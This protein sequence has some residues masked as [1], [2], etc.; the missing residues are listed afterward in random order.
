MINFEKVIYETIQ[1]SM[2]DSAYKTM[3]EAIEKGYLG[4]KVLEEIKK[5]IDQYEGKFDYNAEP[6]ASNFSTK[7]LSYEELAPASV[8]YMLE[9]MKKGRV[10][11]Y[12]YRELK[13]AIVEIESYRK[14]PT[15]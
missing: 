14:T 15:K 1:M 9:A 6:L 7:R 8:A 2:V 11:A 12:K 5:T 13:Q 4:T 3:K 10:T